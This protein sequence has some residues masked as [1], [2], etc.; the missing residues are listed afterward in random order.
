LD[1]LPGTLSPESNNRLT[2][3]FDEIEDFKGNRARGIAFVQ[4]F[5]KIFNGTPS[6]SLKKG[7]DDVELTIIVVDAKFGSFILGTPFFKLVDV[8]IKFPTGARP[9]SAIN[10]Q[11]GS[12]TLRRITITGSIAEDVGE[13]P[14]DPGLVAALD[15]PVEGTDWD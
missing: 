12:S 14:I 8:H 4:L 10:W 1:I 13:N 7:G 11:L 5:F 6:F 9:E 15:H 2:P 3:C